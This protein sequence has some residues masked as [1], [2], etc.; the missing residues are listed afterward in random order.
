MIYLCKKIWELIKRWLGYLCRTFTIRLRKQNTPQNNQSNLQDL[1]S[2]ER[3]DSYESIQQHFENLKFIG[4]ITPKIATIEVSLRN[5][6]DRQLGGADS[7]WIL[8]TSDEILKEELKRINK[9]E[10]IVAPQTLS[11]HQYLSKVSLGIIIHLIKENNLQNALLNLDDIDFKKYS[12]S[13]RNH[14]FFGPNK[15]SDF[16]NI[17]KVDIVLSLLQNIRNRSYHWENIFKT[18]NKNGKTYPRL[19]TKLNNTFIGVESNKIHLFLDDLLNT[20]SKELLD[21]IKRV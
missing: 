1:L 16:L 21:I 2:K 10:K 19:T 9:R 12:S 6:L 14:Y 11:H 8:N 15:S 4:D 7:N 17:N 5:L 20:I 13:N 18:R 3:L